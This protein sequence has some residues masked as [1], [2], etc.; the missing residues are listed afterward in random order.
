LVSILRLR[1]GLVLLWSLRFYV[2]F[3]EFGRY[4]F[5]LLYDLNFVLFLL[6]EDIEVLDMTSLED[7]HFVDGLLRRH[8][9]VSPPVLCS[10]GNDVLEGD[11]LL[12]GVY[13]V[14]P[15]LVSDFGD[16]DDSDPLVL[17]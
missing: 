1:G 11:G 14:E 17:E 2:L 15:S 13:L 6:G 8:D 7:D 5:F 9:C 16:R 12:F 4:L 10:I 3:R